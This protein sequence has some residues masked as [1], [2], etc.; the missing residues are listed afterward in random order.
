[1]QT[2]DV[3]ESLEKSVEENVRQSIK[4]LAPHL[5]FSAREAKSMAN[6][7]GLRV[8]FDRS[9]PSNSQELPIGPEYMPHWA[10]P[11]FLFPYEPEKDRDEFTIGHEVTHWYH[12]M[13]NPDA[14][15]FYRNG[16]AGNSPKLVFAEG[17]ANYGGVIWHLKRDPRENNK[18]VLPNHSLKDLMKFS[19]ED[20]RRFSSP[21]LLEV[22]FAEAV[23][24]YIPDVEHRDKFIE[25]VKY[26][27]R[28]IKY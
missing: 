5:G 3:N 1:M 4:F 21:H 11:A 6:K 12:Y 24:P 17:L 19:A 2:L 13:M 18:V 25:N 20:V 10:P 15:E 28:C 14:G 22:L 8:V 9:I 27:M 7:T 23:A 26:Y 16:I